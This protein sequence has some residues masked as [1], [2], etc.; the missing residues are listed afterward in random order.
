MRIPPGVSES[1]Y[2][3]ALQQFENVVGVDNVYIEDADLD[4]YRDAYSILWD[5]PEEP[6]A[7]GAIA[8]LNVEEVQA[9]VRIA[10]QYKIPLYAISTGRNLG[11]GGSAPVYSGSV[12]LDLKRMNRVIEINEA[13]HYCIVEPG[14][15][16]FDLY[17]EFERRNIKLKASM[18]A[19]GWGS[20]IG[21]ALDHGR[22][23]PAGDNF[24]NSSGMEVVLGDGRLIRTGMGALPGGKT[25]ATFPVGVGPTLDGIFSQSNFGIVTKM[26]FNLFPWPETTRRIGIATRNYDNLDAMVAVCNELQAMGVGGGS[27][28]FSPLHQVLASRGQEPRSHTTTELNRLAADFDTD[29]IAMN[30][31]FSGPDKVTQ[32]QFEVAYDML[33]AAVPD[34]NLREFPVSRAPSSHTTATDRDSGIIGKPNLQRFWEDT[35]QYDWDGHMWF[36]PLM[37]QTG[38]EFRRS[39]EVFG[40]I[41][42]EEDVFWGLPP[43]LLYN[44]TN[45]GAAASCYCIVKNFNVSKTDKAYNRRTLATSKRLIRA[46]AEN[47]WS[48]YRG[49]AALQEEIMDTFSFND[50]AY[51]RFCETVKDAIDPNGILSAGRYGIWPKHLRENEA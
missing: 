39:M 46:A 27:G 25:W 51:M 30:L 19:P 10:N 18:P 15:S 8:P 43:A 48:E 26:G 11:Y 7:A 42:R 29:L 36:S 45:M 47:G 33:A 13:E 6:I 22:G 38:E 2:T 35:A 1:D 44:S 16:F 41:C 24:R 49:A 20:P 4:L 32:A 21:N 14:V 34:A 23:G 50:H 5:E 9:V 17:A 12:I 31:A 28:V 37:P 40:A 3:E